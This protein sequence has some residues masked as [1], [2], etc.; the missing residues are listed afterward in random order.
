MNRPKVVVCQSASLDG[1]LTLS[2]DTLLLYGDERWSAMMGSSDGD[3]YAQVKAAY[4][5]QVILEGSG[6]FMLEGM[7]PDPLPPVEGDPTSLYQDFLPEAIV[8]RP[9]HRGWFTV[10]DSRGR[11]RWL[12]KEYPGDE[13]AG[14]YMLILAARCTPPEYLAY[15]QRENIP[16][17]VAGEQRVDLSAA[18]EKL[19]CVFGVT[20][21]VST[22]GG[23]FNG[24]LLRAGLVD[25][26]EIEFFPAVIGGFDTPS[27]FNSPDLKLDEWP[28]RLELLAVRQRPNG[29]VW[30]H[31]RVLPNSH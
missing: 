27:L 20:S 16:Y 10:V 18:L 14:W 7:V 2:P 4:Q 8:N 22:A 28:T 25:E 15:L 30:L 26:I 17:L 23:R 24:A 11:G 3:F 6:S 19:Q 9:G 29:C 31:Y 12:Y 21:V 1:R 13:W 5:P